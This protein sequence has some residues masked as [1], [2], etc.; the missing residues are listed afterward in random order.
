MTLAPSATEQSAQGCAANPHAPLGLAA[1]GQ[2]ISITPPG[3][4]NRHR[5][6]R[7]PGWRLDLEKIRGA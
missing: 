5:T 7:L 6:T 4:D 2:R 1:D 3:G